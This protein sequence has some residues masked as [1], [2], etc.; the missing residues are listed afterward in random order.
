MSAPTYGNQFCGSGLRLQQFV[1][2]W[3]VG[4]RSCAGLCLRFLQPFTSQRTKIMGSAKLRRI[5]K[6]RHL[7]AGR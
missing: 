5:Q 7:G 3:V 6:W 2:D 1:I 4:H